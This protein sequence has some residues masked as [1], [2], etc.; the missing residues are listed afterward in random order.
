MSAAG[1]RSVDLVVGGERLAAKVVPSGVDADRRLSHAIA[2]NSRTLKLGGD[3]LKRRKRTCR[4]S[5]PRQSAP[6]KLRL[7]E[8]LVVKERGDNTNKDRWKGQGEIGVGTAGGRV[9][10]KSGEV[11]VEK[12]SR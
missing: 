8:R 3:A 7:K 5:N 11:S 12:E 2:G 6:L 1:P 4:Q 9:W 10:V